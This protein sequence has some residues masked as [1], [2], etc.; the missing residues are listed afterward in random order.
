M[1]AIIRKATALFC[2]VATALATIVSGGGGAWAQQRRGM[3]LLSDAETDH[4]IRAMAGPIFQAAGIDPGAVRIL[5]VNDGTLNAFVSGGQNI[6]LHTGLILEA[7]PLQL[8][9]VIAH[10]TGHISGGHLVRGKDAMDNAMLS[11]LIGLGLG[12]VG[13]LAAGKADAALGGALLGQQLAQRSFLAF[14]RTQEASADQAG[15]SYLNRAGISAEGMLTFLEKLDHENP[16][17]NNDRDVGYRLTHPLTRERIEFLRQSVA[18]SPH[19]GKP[20]AEKWRDAHARLQAKL[21]AFLEPGRALARY[22]ADDH[23]VAARYGRA[24]AH[25][26]RGDIAAAMPLVDGL[27]REEPKNAYFQ[28]MKGDLLLQTGRAADAAAP[29]RAAI[30]LAPDAVSIRV[31]LAHALL[32]TNDPRVADE[33]IRNLNVASKTQGQASFLWRLMARAWTLKGNDG[34]VAYA[35]AEEA[36]ASGDRGRARVMAERALKLLPTGSPGWLRAQDIGGQLRGG[37]DPLPEGG[38][39]EP[40]R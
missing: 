23:S 10:E 9:G 29:Y 14:S 8:L 12:V 5:L 2:A 1:Q 30:A 37:R 27:I 31:S 6:F 4:I 15:L 39:P 26:R 20:L 11:S 32:E 25:F 16:V 3:Q 21:F 40:G 35:A 34:M 13:G 33:A 22:R 36:F 7:D 28:E 38:K 19:T 17:L 24:Y 18:Q